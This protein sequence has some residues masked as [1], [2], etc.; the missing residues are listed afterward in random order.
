MYLQN[1]RSTEYFRLLE[2]KYFFRYDLVFSELCGQANNA[3]R[4]HRNVYVC[5]YTCKICYSFRTKKS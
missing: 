4:L 2:Q 3:V 5:D 1:K